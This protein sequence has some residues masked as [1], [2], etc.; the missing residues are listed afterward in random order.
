[1]VGSFNLTKPAGFRQ[2][3]DLVTTRD[4]DF[5][6]SL[7]GTFREYAQD[8]RVARPYQVTDL[9]EQKITL[10]PGIGHN[11]IREELERVKCK[12]PA[13]D[14]VN[15]QTRTRIRIAIAGWFDAFGTDIAKQVRALWAQGCNIKIITTLAGHG[16][17]RTLRSRKG[18]GP[19][20]IRR[21]IID[22]NQDRVPERYLHMKAVAIKGVFDGD[23]SA[24]VLLTGS[25]NW[26]ARANRSDEILFRFLD[27][28]KLVAQYSAHVDRLFAQQ[29]SR[30]KTTSKQLLGRYLEGDESLPGWF[31]LD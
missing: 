10:W 26:S 17:N 15:G 31:E 7:V 14:V 2:W 5:Y 28:P 8:K 16:T 11:T 1:M 13:A 27:V 3:N 24:D 22:R 9:G 19:V 21:V 12:I 20:P 6:Q 29:F 18:R 30:G 25:P 4:P 23:T